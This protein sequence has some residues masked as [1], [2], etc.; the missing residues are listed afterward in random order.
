[1]FVND[2]QL[3]YFSFVP[4]LD[5]RAYLGMTS[6]DSLGILWTFQILTYWLNLCTVLRALLGLAKRK[7]VGLI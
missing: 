6:T 3:K 7:S 4:I 2:G 1:M 5:F